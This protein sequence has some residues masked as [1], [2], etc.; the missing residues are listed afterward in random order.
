VRVPVIAEEAPAQVLEGEGLADWM[1][2]A[3]FIDEYVMVAEM[4]DLEALE[5]RSLAEAKR[6]P[7]WPL[8]EKAIREELATLQEAGT[9]ELTDTPNGANIVGS[10]WVFRAK[11]DAA[12]NVARYK[13]RLV[14]Q[15][16][17]QVPGVDY[18]DTF[19][20]VAKLASIRAVLAMA[21]AKDMELHQIDIKGAYLNGELTERETICMS[22]PPV[23]TLLILRLLAKLCRLRKTLYGLK[24]SGRRWYQKLVEIKRCD[25]DQ[26]VFFSTRR[27]QAHC[28]AC[29][30]R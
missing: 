24:Q 1:M 28:C 12:G 14:A 7:E 26:A 3:D 25:V 18:F 22:Q 19:A 29:S 11:K 16:F 15:G 17:S 6:R 5:L 30:C 10:K 23:I 2:T 27:T 13:A 20:P 9:W 4:S 8:W 21:T